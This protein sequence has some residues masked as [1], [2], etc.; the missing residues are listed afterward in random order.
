MIK[1]VLFDLDG[2][3]LDTNDLILASFREAFSKCLGMNLDDKEISKHFG[4]PLEDSFSDYADKDIVKEMIK[5]YR[6]YND[7]NHDSKCMS[8]EGVHDILKELK[9]KGI[10]LAVVTSKRKIMCERGMKISGIY[11]Y[12][13]VIIT[14]ENTEKHKPDKEPALKACELLEELPEKSLFVGD[15]TFDI[16]CGKAAG[17]YTCAVSYTALPIEELEKV[18]PDYFISKFSELLT[19]IDKIDCK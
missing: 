6:S 9:R 2:T 4:K 19:V 8:F 18:K 3:L 17:C 14:P 15:S 5:T 1:A 16:L 13:D 12:I 7:A 11:D 10:K